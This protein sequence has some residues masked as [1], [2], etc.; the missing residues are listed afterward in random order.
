[1]AR[2]GAIA[3]K[4]V[5][6]FFLFVLSAN[7]WGDTLQGTVLLQQG[8]ETTILANQEVLLHIYDQGIHIASAKTK[9]SENGG[10]TFDVSERTN[11]WYFRV[12]VPYQTVEFASDYFMDPDQSPDITVSKTTGSLENVGINEI[13]FFEFGS[14]QLVKISHEIEIINRG[15]T[16]YH[17]EHP[18]AQVLSFEL[19][20]GGFSLSM[21]EG[22]TRDKVDVDEER[23]TLILKKMLPPQESHALRF[24]YMLPLDTKY[25]SLNRNDLAQH[26]SLALLSNKKSF[27][28][29]SDQFESRKDVPVEV[30][31]NIDKIYL[32]TGPL[33]AV[34][35]KIK[36]YARP[37]DAYIYA[38]GG[39]ALLIM[40]GMLTGMILTPTRERAQTEMQLREEIQSLALEIKENPDPAKLEKIDLLKRKLYHMLYTTT[41]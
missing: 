15:S 7:A 8:E 12:R 24:S 34:S 6:F 16:T 40:I 25:I 38:F 27:R 41:S 4:R 35:A 32:A 30:A 33:E 28:V 21:V 39:F 17:P 31:D 37:K 14:S 5:W 10:Y 29:T 13:M 22:I 9:T 3:L 2:D 18:E 36:G 26:D 1:M 19:I 23:H 11:D 20:E